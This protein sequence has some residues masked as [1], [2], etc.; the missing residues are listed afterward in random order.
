MESRDSLSSQSLLQEEHSQHHNG[1]HG[2]TK[3]LVAPLLTVAD[4]DGDRDVDWQDMQDIASRI[5]LSSGEN[6]YHPL[7]DLDANGELNIVDLSRA[8]RTLGAEVPLLDQ[9]IAQVTQATMKYYGPNGLQSALADGYIPMTPEAIGHGIHY[10]NPRL[11]DKVVNLEQLDIQRPVGLNYDDQGKLV[12]VFYIR[13]PQRQEPTP[14]NPF[15]ELLIDPTDNFPARVSFDTIS[16]DDWHSHE[17]AWS[18]GVGNLNPESVYFEEDVPFETI[19]SRVQQEQFKLF[20][21]SDNFYS[22]QF[23]MLHGWF[24]SLNPEGV[25]ANT[26]P[27]VALYAFEELGAHSPQHSTNPEQ[28]TH[29]IAGT[30][31]TDQLDAREQW[32]DTHESI[33]ING[34]GGDDLV[35]GNLVDNLLWGGDGD[36]VMRGDHNGFSLSLEEGGSDMLYGGPGNDLLHGQGG[37]DRLFGGIGNDQIWGD[38]GDDLLR[39]GLGQDILK[40]D[41]CESNNRGRDSFVLAAGEGTDII[42][43]FEVGLD[44]LVL[45]GGLSTKQLSINQRENNTLIDYGSETLAI[46]NGV[47]ANELMLAGTFTFT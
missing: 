40:G 42:M 14:G 4:F 39:G 46:L 22:P 23:W 11:A 5:F 31:S 33:R 17:N 12:A 8:V 29:L 16:G 26:N 9:Q 15:A 24:H 36:D 41:D 1:G 43:D 47:N 7:Y 30:D 19:V 21:E 2:D 44:L 35:I 38:E 32:G 28:H 3:N 10:Y 25:F 6:N 45:V 37:N 20:P 18:V 27:K 34:F 13:M